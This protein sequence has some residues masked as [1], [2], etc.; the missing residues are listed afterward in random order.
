[1]INYEYV[2]KE[3]MKKQNLTWQRIPDHPYRIITI[4][5]SESGK[6]N[7]LVNLIK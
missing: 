1:M 7:S 3:N 4:G 2:T 5:G 6:T